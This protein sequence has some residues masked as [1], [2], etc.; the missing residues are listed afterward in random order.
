MHAAPL[1]F[2]ILHDDARFEHWQMRC[3]EELGALSDV[4]ADLLISLRRPAH[5][6]PRALG[7]VAQILLARAPT[8]DEL[9]I[10]EEPLA[11][12]KSSDLDFVLS[13]AD[14]VCP[15]RLMDAARYGVWRF[16][17]GDWVRYR[18][19]P[20]GF[21]EV[22]DGAS[23]SSALLTRLLPDRDS[24]LVLR[25]G[26]FRTQSLSYTRN[27]EHILS[28]VS[29]WPAQVCLD[30]RN[31]VTSRFSANAVRGAVQV[32]SA[33]ARRQLFICAC[34]IAAR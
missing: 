20:P 14:V 22:Y 27:R 26:H 28:R 9:Q 31:G 34:R 4:R 1:R 30:I 11:R 6:L 18:G 24:V 17:F 16:H 33:P 25:D 15:A 21:W 29:R 13:F 19:G 10:E 23:V 2:A 8:S 32:R 12:L 7:G 3:L 5:E